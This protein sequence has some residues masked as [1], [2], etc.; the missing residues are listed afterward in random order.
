MRARPTEF[1]VKIVQE[2]D[3]FAGDKLASGEIRPIV[4]KTYK[5]S[6]AKEAHEYMAAKKNK[7]KIVLVVK[8]G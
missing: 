8:D 4:D 1:K 5:L 6:E 7:G 3:K 2:F